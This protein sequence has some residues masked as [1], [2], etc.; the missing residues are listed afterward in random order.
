METQHPPTA[1]SFDDSGWCRPYSFSAAFEAGWRAFAANYGKL[2]G[3]TL[4]YLLIYIATAF[5]AGLVDA[6]LMG[7]PDPAIQ[8]VS[9]LLGWLFLGPLG[10]GLTYVGVAAVRGEAGS[11][12]NLFIAFRRYG[13]VLG[14]MLLTSLIEMGIGL[15]AAAPALLVGATVSTVGVLVIV[16]LVVVAVV[17]AMYVNVRLWFAGVAAVDPSGPGAGVVDSIKIAW[18][19]T[20][21][22]AA[23]SLLGL[24][25]VVMVMVVATFAMLILPGFFF[26]APLTVAVFGAAYAL[27]AGQKGVAPLEGVCRRC[28]YPVEGATVCPECGLGVVQAAV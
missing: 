19:M 21:G 22:G 5:M 25:I 9:L 11:L 27:L 8:P 23:W 28:G 13:V 10:L 26:G 14:I 20:R 18:A 12:D 4:V 24:L 1:P 16:P 6:R 17:V 2:L 3:A 7:A 15:L